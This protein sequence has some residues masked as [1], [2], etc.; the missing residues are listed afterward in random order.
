[1]KASAAG[2]WTL[3]VL[4]PADGNPLGA[5]IGYVEFAG[6]VPEG[7]PRWLLA[8]EARTE[9]RFTRRFE[10]TRLAS[11]EIDRQ[12]SSPRLLAMFQRWQDAAWKRQS[13]S[14]R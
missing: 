11:G 10:V 7:E 4:P 1:M 14:L 3:D 8:R 5:D 12:A 9:G 6:W 2:E 13:V